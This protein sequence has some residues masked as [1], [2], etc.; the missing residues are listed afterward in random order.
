[1]CYEYL[2]FKNA[3]EVP[4]LN[5]TNIKSAVTYILSSWC[6]S[7]QKEEKQKHKLFS[8]TSTPP[9]DPCRTGSPV[10]RMRK[11]AVGRKGSMGSVTAACRASRHT[12]GCVRYTL[13]SKPRS[14]VFAQGICLQQKIP[15]PGFVPRSRGAETVHWVTQQIIFVGGSLFL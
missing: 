15:W 7:K 10:E 8:S 6:H 12:S 5:I 11:C 9:G 14:L 3:D 4:G 2:F 1:M 13:I